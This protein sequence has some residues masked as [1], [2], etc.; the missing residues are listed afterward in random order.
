MTISVRQEGKASFIANM[1]FKGYETLWS[2]NFP[3]E[4]MMIRNLNGCYSPQERSRFSVEN[5]I[6]E[7]SAANGHPCHSHSLLAKPF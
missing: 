7:T 1:Q 6:D 2:S 4:C 5:D 3:E